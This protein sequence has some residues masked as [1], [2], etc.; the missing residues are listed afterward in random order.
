MQ[1]FKYKY[2]LSFTQQFFVY[3]GYLEEEGCRASYRTFLGESQHLQEYM[4][5][6]EIGYQY[7]TSI[8][9]QSLTDMLEAYTASKLEGRFH[10]S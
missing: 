8:A 6:V 9:G 5:L 2:V 10:T 3:K 1:Y 4:N 7:P